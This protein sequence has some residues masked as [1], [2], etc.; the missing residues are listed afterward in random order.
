V[1]GS[2][3]NSRVV[4]GGGATCGAGASTRFQRLAAHRGLEAL[5]GRSTNIELPARARRTR[6]AERGPRRAV[7]QRV[8]YAG[9]MRG[10]KTDPPPPFAGAGLSK[11]AGAVRR[12]A[13]AATA[14]KDGA[15]GPAPQPAN[16]HLDVGGSKRPGRRA[17]WKVAASRRARLRIDSRT[18]KSRGTLAHPYSG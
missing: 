9:G 7:V 13:V 8:R 6:R 12:D 4:D 2:A 17:I 18:R 14:A 16:P 15:A 10:L 3:D 1:R 11:S 5:D